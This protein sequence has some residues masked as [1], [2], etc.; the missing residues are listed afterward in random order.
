MPP[1]GKKTLTHDTQIHSEYSGTLLVL[2]DFSL[3]DIIK[4]AEM[5]YCVLYSAVTLTES[6]L[7]H[8]EKTYHKK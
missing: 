2:N 3:A 4:Y 5:S 7:E 1:G 8:T 6:H